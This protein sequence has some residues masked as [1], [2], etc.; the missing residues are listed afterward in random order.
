MTE[1]DCAT[2]QNQCDRRRKPLSIHPVIRHRAPSI[3]VTRSAQPARRSAW[4]VAIANN[5]AVVKNKS[6]SKNSLRTRPI[7][8]SS[9]S[10]GMG[11]KCR[12]DSLE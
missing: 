10:F 2:P 8:A 9:R 7:Q 6:L 11:R 3:R 12:D 5:L 4:T 1:R